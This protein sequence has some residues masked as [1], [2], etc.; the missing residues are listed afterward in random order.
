MTQRRIAVKKKRNTGFCRLKKSCRHLSSFVNYKI[1]QFF[2]KAK[3]YFLSQCQ[4]VQFFVDVYYVVTNDDTI[5]CY[6]QNPQFAF[7]YKSGLLILLGLLNL[8]KNT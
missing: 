5:L 2:A 6:D 3:L 4:Q 7:L 1:F 8:K